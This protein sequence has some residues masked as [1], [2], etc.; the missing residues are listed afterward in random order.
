[1]KQNGMKNGFNVTIITAGSLTFVTLTFKMRFCYLQ[2]C[3]RVLKHKA[4]QQTTSARHHIGLIC[5][6]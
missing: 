2:P 1:M 6:P 3:R 5:S 4:K